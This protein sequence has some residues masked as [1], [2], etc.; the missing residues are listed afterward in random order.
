VTRNLVFVVSTLL[1]VVLL[2]HPANAQPQ[3]VGEAP[4]SLDS[5]RILVQVKINGKGP[6]SMIIRTGTP[7]SY[8]DSTVAK[9]TAARVVPLPFVT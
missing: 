8:V 9:E 3:S 5:N 4:F 2:G 6:Y 7:H 1:I